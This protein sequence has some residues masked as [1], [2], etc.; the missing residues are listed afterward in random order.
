MTYFPVVFKTSHMPLVREAI[1]TNLAPNGTFQDAFRKLLKR[2][3]YSQ[4]NLMCTYAWY[5]LRDQYHWVVDEYEPGWT[6]VVKG[7]VESRDE[8]GLEYFQ[9]LQPHLTMHWVYENMIRN[10]MH[11]KREM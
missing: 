10:K 2:R 11:W 8:I 7:Q 3:F 5:H 9:R 1:T 4:F 6:G